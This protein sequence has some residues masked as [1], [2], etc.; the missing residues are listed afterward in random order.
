MLCFVVCFGSV[1]GGDKFDL[2]CSFILPQI[3]QSLTVRGPTIRL[4]LHSYTLVQLSYLGCNSVP[5]DNLR[6]PNVH[7]DDI[8]NNLLKTQL[9]RNMDVEV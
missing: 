7:T 8:C 5:H 6:V 1:T 2:A 9:L 3:S 4:A